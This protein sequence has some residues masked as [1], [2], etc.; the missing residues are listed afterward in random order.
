MASP[1]MNIPPSK[2]PLTKEEERVYIV[3]WCTLRWD[4]IYNEDKKAITAL[5][6]KYPDIAIAT[7][8]SAGSVSGNSS[9]A[10]SQISHLPDTPSGLSPNRMWEAYHKTEEMWKNASTP[11]SSPSVNAFNTDSLLVQAQ[12][13]QPNAGP[14]VPPKSLPLTPSFPPQPYPLPPAA[15][16]FTAQSSLSPAGPSVGPPAGPPPG[17]LPGTSMPFPTP[18]QPRPTPPV[19]PQQQQQQFTPSSAFLRD[20]AQRRSSAMSR[21]KTAAESFRDSMHKAVDAETE[22]AKCIA[23]IHELDRLEKEAKGGLVEESPKE[24]AKTT[25]S[26]RR[27]RKKKATE[28]HGAHDEGY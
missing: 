21:Q 8:F 7:H 10:L 28:K 26:K 16:P 2:Y 13:Q 22:M 20:L 18:V 5:T 9:V 4:L 27:E 24:R 14:S 15:S 12:Q 19:V 23:E 6:S 3:M 17:P 1:G 11:W 25:A